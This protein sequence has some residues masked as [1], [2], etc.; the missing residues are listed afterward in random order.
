MG[1]K[2]GGEWD[3][4]VEEIGIERWRR[5]GKRGGG[6]WE[7][8]VEKIGIERW[9]RLGQRGGEDWDREVKIG[10]ERWRR[11]GQRGGED[12]DREVEK[13]GKERWRKLE[14]TGGPDCKTFTKTKPHTLYP[15]PSYSHLNVTPKR[16]SM[17]QQSSSQTAVG[18]FL[19]PRNNS[20]RKTSS[21]LEQY[22]AVFSLTSPRHPP[23]HTHTMRRPD[24]TY[25]EEKRKEE[26]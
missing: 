11:L 12:W 8:E 7:R 14:W 23:P 13:I 2:G 10:T 20:T 21:S 24:N 26:K 3:R 5:L 22:L 1:L 25:E 17:I 15:R 19:E 9:R 18:S 16:Y 6:Y 4:E